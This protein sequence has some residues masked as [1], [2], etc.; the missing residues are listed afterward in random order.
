M[1][2]HLF[3]INPDS[4]AQKITSADYEVGFVSLVKTSD[5]RFNIVDIDCCNHQIHQA[6]S[7]NELD[8]LC[9]LSEIYKPRLIQSRPNQIPKLSERFE[10]TTK[11]PSFYSQIKEIF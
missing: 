4:H 1:V 3:P 10:T 11:L 9:L 6:V 8:A 7:E 5:N 2:E